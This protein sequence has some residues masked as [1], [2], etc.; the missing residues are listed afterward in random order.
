MGNRIQASKLL[1]QY[2]L[3][4][5][6]SKLSSK[7]ALKI[8]ILMSFIDENEKKYLQNIKILLNTNNTKEAS[9]W[10]DREIKRLEIRDTYKIKK[11]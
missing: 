4:K 9:R 10:L 7:W 8:Y 2:E 5:K 6:L 1:K 11:Y 3:D